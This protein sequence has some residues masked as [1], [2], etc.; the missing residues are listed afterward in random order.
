MSER[1]FVILVCGFW[2]HY[3]SASGKKGEAGDGKG[4]GSEWGTQ[5][6]AGASSVWRI[7]SLLAHQAGRRARPL[8]IADSIY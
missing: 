6:E 5:Y 2:S 4:E 3:L 1:P 7:I 8:V